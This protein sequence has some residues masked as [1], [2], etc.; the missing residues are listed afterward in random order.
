MADLEIANPFKEQTLGAHDNDSRI[1]Q[2]RQP[3]LMPCLGRSTGIGNHRNPISLA[4]QPDRRLQHAD[5]GFQAGE[6]RSFPPGAVDP[7]QDVGLAGEAEHNLVEVFAGLGNA[8]A[9]PGIRR[10]DRIDF[11]GGDK[12]WNVEPIPPP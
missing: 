4:G 7:F 2:A 8:A 6:H 11:F 5:V 9:D 3:M 10:A 12:D 1:A